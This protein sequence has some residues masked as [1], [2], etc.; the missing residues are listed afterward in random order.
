MD[1]LD[2][3]ADTF[4]DTV[5][6]SDLPVLVDF[7]GEVCGPCKAMAL[8]LPDMVKKYG[9][10]LKIVKLNATQERALAE[11]YEIRSVPALIFFTNGEPVQKHQGF[12]TKTH[13]DALIELFLTTSPSPV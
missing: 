3:T 10:H 1:I 4:N 5:L 7:W 6:K 8:F 13:L 11:Q 2:V 9:D 12:K